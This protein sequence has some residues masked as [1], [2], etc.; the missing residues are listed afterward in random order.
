MSDKK[1]HIVLCGGAPFPSKYKS[2]AKS[3]IHRFH[4]N[5]D[6]KQNR[7]NIGLP[8]LVRQVN[9][10]FPPRI[11][12]LLEIAGYVYA[13]DRMTKRGQPI[14]LEYQGWSR[15][16]HFF[17]KVRDHKFWQKKT[18]KES[19]SKILTY[20]TGDLSY[21]FSFLEGGKDVGQ[22]MLFDDPNF[23]LVK[24]ENTA[25]SLFSGGLDSLAGALELLHTTDNDLILV[26]HQSNNFAITKIQ[27]SIY[28]LL[29]NDYPGR[30]QRFPFT[31]S[32]SGDRA[33]EET[34]RSRIFLYTSIAF[35]L[36]SLANE[37][38]IHVYENGMTSLNFPKRQ[39]MMNARS[40]RTTHPQTIFL[41]EAFFNS[42]SKEKIKIKQPF[43][44]ITKAEVIERIHLYGKINYLNSTIT[45]TKTFNISKKTSPAN[46]C[47][48]CSQCID[49]RFASISTGLDDYDAIY[50]VD[51]LQDSIDDDEGYTH[52]CDYIAAAKRFSEMSAFQFPEI[53][54]AEL[55]EI[56]DYMP[57]ESNT[58][59]VQA[60][61][62][63]TQRHSNNVLLALKKIR[64]NEDVFKP[65]KNRSIFSFLDDRV[66]L[67][68]PV[69][70]LVV[71]ICEKMKSAI[72]IA[73]ERSK[74]SHENVL[75][76]QINALLVSEHGDYER[77]FPAIKFAF[78]RT[79][80]DHSFIDYNLLIEAKLLKRES[81]KADFTNQI[82]SDIIKYGNSFKLFLLYDPERKIVNDEDFCKYFKNQPNCFIQIIR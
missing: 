3:H 52:L 8:H 74:P 48:I 57:G 5:P 75:N 15:K 80:P 45:C 56:I 28:N 58:K 38:T 66:Y 43:F 76:D 14:Q 69:E 59:K 70:R 32:L 78:A 2:L 36:M 18:I 26:S 42:I 49:R 61:Y 17:I 21:E 34:Q 4:C 73:F 51:I 68:P 13:A 25:I 82:A 35:S 7:I 79:V 67:R 30:V 81:S 22:S 77:E 24:K 54:L 65:K 41:L 55:N 50:D 10:Y 63:L 29:S 37:K 44:Y 47:G 6:I 20:T 9:C 16:F 33:I 12:D 60:I 72:P 19:L 40:S 62:E 39:D 31:C 11:K 23:K 71:S 27:N 46:H 1:L 53:M 64:Q